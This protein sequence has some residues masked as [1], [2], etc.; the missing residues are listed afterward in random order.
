MLS[1]KKGVVSVFITKVL[2]AFIGLLTVV[3]TSR[4]LGAQGRGTISLFTSSVALVQLFCDFGS[5]S[6]IINLSYKINQWKLWL[7][8]AIWILIIGLFAYLIA[9]LVPIE[10][11]FWVP[12]VAVLFSVLNL[13]NM[14]LMGNRMVVQRNVLLV[15]QPVLLLIIF[16]GFVYFEY[17]INIAYPMAFLLA[18]SLTFLVSAFFIVPK[19]KAAASQMLSFRFEKQILTNGLWV[20]GGHA[21][22]FLNYR[23]NFFIIVFFIGNAALGIYNNALV[24]AESLWILGH[25]IG[26]MM[27]MKILN[28]DNP[29][30]HRNLTF[31]MLL[32]N[33]S[34]TMVMLVVLLLI[35]VSFWEWLFSKEFGRIKILFFAMSPGILFFSI[36]NILNHFFHAKNQFKF[37]LV[38]NLV[39]L[40]VGITGSFIFIPLY[41][42]V[43]ACIS[44]SSA[45][46]VSMLF[47]LYR[48]FRQP[49]SNTQG[50]FGE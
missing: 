25:S 35:P 29:I 11:V 47:Y 8:A 28:S 15:L 27:H 3:V 1:L 16:T 44:W 30:E 38:V 12:I 23:I 21:I 4:Y 22:Q 39:G 42:L 24:I 10:Y 49:F 40:F 32:L 2:V 20:Q 14:L 17:L 36:S 13:N 9:F 18:V 33:F 19:L 45:L 41:G 37:I 48:F 34:G 7:S 46:T 6:A 43:G 5:S 31:R 26:Q 50:I